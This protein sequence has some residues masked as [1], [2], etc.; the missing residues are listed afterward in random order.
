M[1]N[2]PYYLGYLYYKSNK[3]PK[4]YKEYVYYFEKKINKIYNLIDLIIN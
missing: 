4:K 1:R 2:R 3:V